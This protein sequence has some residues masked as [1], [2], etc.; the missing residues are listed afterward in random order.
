[1]AVVGDEAL[2]KKKLQCFISSTEDGFPFEGFGDFEESK[3]KGFGKNISI[4][5]CQIIGIQNDN[6]TYFKSFSRLIILNHK[7]INQMKRLERGLPHI[8]QITSIVQTPL[9]E[10]LASI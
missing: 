9:A 2:L 1:M 8:I 5:C 10:D 3:E 6:L 7:L 4:I